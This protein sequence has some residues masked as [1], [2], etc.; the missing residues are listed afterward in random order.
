MSPVEM[1]GLAACLVEWELKGDLSGTKTAV[2][3]T[4]RSVLG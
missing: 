3:Q 2:G 4:E 1:C